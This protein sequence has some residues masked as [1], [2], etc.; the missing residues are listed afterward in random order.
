M[1]RA[2]ID[3]LLFAIDQTDAALRMFADDPEGFV[4]SWEQDHGRRDGGAWMGGSLTREEREAF[5]RWDYGALYGMG[6]HPSLL[7]QAVRA[8][9]ADRP[10][11]DVIAG[12]R[13][14]IEPYGRPSFGT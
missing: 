2:E 5:I 11:D 7:W 14:A 1:S 8:L 9:A 13:Q 4:T 3:L 6:A 12:Y 10:I